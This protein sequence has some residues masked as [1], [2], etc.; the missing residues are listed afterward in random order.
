MEGLV[1]WVPHVTNERKILVDK[2]RKALRFVKLHGQFDGKRI[3][4]R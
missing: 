4:R 3:R 1:S 2:P